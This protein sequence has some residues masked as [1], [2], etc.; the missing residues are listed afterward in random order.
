MRIYLAPHVLVERVGDS[1]VLLDTE[2][3][4]VYSLP[5]D[6][7]SF[8]TAQNTTLE[9]DRSLYAEV[10]N[11]CELGLATTD[12]QGLS[13]RAV[14]GMGGVA[15][16]GTLLTLSLPLSA[17]ASS[18]SVGT[19]FGTW[20]LESFNADVNGAVRILIRVNFDPNDFTTLQGDLDDWTLTIFGRVFD[21]VENEY[22]P[23][24]D[25]EF[26]RTDQNSL[27]KMEELS[28]RI[29]ADPI[30]PPTDISGTMSDGT[31]TAEI[32]FEFDPPEPY[33]YGSG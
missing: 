21:L 4:N 30:E 16:G 26:D 11:L 14:V 5:E 23:G 19:V 9:L 6:A 10:R 2:A 3:R 7:V 33:G 1:V 8:P 12:K 13:R 15:M 18:G 28:Q 27:D 22:Y 20:A 31:R 17:A 32:V 24:Y 29:D 25:I